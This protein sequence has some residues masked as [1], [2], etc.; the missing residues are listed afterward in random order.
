MT[1]KDFRQE[2]NTSQQIQTVN[3][4]SAK[5][6]S[7]GKQAYKELIRAEQEKK[8]TEALPKQHPNGKEDEKSVKCVHDCKVS[9]VQ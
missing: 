5:P 1:Q 7:G 3:V 2:I 8:N 6:L 9:R 4:E